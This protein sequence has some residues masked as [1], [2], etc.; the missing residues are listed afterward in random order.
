MQ[1][2]STKWHN[3]RKGRVTGSV[4]GAILGLAPYMTRDDVMRRMV[5]DYHG[6]APEFTG[7]VA[8]EWGVANE[9]GAMFEFTMKTGFDV[10]E[11]G[12]FPVDDW[13]G[14]SP[15]ALVGDDSVI[16]IKFPFGLRDKENPVFKSAQD[17]PH[18]YAKMQIEMYCTT[19]RKCYF[20]QW[21]PKGDALE[22][23]DYDAP[24]VEENLP[25]LRQFHAAF[26]TEINNPAHLEPK[27][28][29]IETV[30]ASKLIE[31]YDN[32]AM[33]LEVGE[34]RKRDILASLE[35]ISGGRDSIIC[36]RNFTK[37]ERAGSVSYAK[38]L[39][40]IAPD[41]DLTPWRGKPTEYWKLT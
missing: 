30:E 23:V 18:Y 22:V 32:I 33:A 8:T 27:R 7:N 15:D 12:F 10:Q 28:R 34:A 5:R 37:V 25:V 6:A 26:L 4:A 35:K 1:Q 29:I 19:R 40:A 21:A 31:E 36:G 38:A 39:K 13:L 16:E 2:R 20:Y 24:W 14:A 9:S 41:A 3:A 17:Q 11:C